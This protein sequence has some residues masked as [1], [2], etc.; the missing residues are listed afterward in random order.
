MKLI[1]ITELN[2]YTRAVNTIAKYAE[3]CKTLGHEVAI[4]SEQQAETP[5][6]P[7]SLELKKFDFAIFVI[8]NTTDFPDLPYLAQ[9]L[10]GIPKDR[11]VIIDCSGRYN[12]TIR[13][14]HDFNHLERLE[15]HQGWEWVEGFQAVAS[16]VLQ[17][18]LNPLRP[19]V[20]PFLF[21]GYDPGAVARPY[22]S[23]R[24]AVQFWS[25]NGGRGKPYGV[26]Y[27]GNNWQRWHQLR[28]FLEAIEPLR[29][30]LGPTCLVGWNWDKQPDWAA[31]MDFHGMDVD[32]ALLQRMG[33][34]VKTGISFHE[35]VDFGGKGRFSPILHR[36]LFNELGLVTNRTFETFCSD[37]IPLALIPDRVSEAIYGPAAALLAPGGDIAEH[38]RNILVDPE[39]YW[40]AIL[41][42]RA[43]LAEHHSYQ[44]RVKELVT[45]LE[46]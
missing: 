2:R 6:I 3:V 7:C 27:I 4:F 40:D 5:S 12:E 43:H 19:D 16:K 1:M 41:S 42:T 26:V 28:S 18:T 9:I 13:V 24:E 35:V 15:G 17:P 38:L 10:D 22:H 46:S 25:G 44:Q 11:R 30:E 37:T 31:E 34:E 20:L 29:G 8:Y 33:V 39:P 32:P 14:D 23:A 45:M 21:H 36:P